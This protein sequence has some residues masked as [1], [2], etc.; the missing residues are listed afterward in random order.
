MPRTAIVRGAVDLV[1]PPPALSAALVSL[2]A[3]P[4]VRALFGLER[5][6]AA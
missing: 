1:L 6:T 4:G 2:V 5:R 3:V